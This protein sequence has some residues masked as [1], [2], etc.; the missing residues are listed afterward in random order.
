MRR[1]FVFMENLLLMVGDDAAILGP[2]GTMRGL[3]D[4]SVKQKIR[5]DGRSRRRA[6]AR[7]TG[8]HPVGGRGI[9]TIA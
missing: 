9:S 8:P 7:R 1:D 6:I 4:D 5:Y 3:G 2:V